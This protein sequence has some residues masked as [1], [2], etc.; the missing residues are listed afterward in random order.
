MTFIQTRKSIAL[1]ER[2]RGNKT[3]EKIS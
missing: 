3:E 1:E 2:N